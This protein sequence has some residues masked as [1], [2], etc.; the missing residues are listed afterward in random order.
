MEIGESDTWFKRI[1][2]IRSR[3]LASTLDGWGGH[4]QARD[5]SPCLTSLSLPAVP[6]F[7]PDRARLDLS[8]PAYIQRPGRRSRR[9]G[10]GER[11]MDGGGEDSRGRRESDPDSDL[12][13]H[14]TVY[15]LSKQWL[16]RESILQMKEGQGGEIW[17]C[18]ER[19]GDRPDVNTGL[20]REK[21]SSTICILT[22]SNIWKMQLV[23]RRRK[24]RHFK[25]QFWR[26][27]KELPSVSP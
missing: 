25:T 6:R 10:R 4:V 24:K 22:I 19:E 17:S 21:G 3:C 12:H 14:S 5:A 1:F 26:S 16:H 7:N 18:R 20:D 13:I 11:R 8:L 23:W 2:F 9:W 15:S 27:G